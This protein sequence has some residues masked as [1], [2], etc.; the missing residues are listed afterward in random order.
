MKR[1][2]AGLVIGACLM[3]VPRAQASTIGVSMGA[4]YTCSVEN[5]G[6]DVS[7]TASPFVAVQQ[8]TLAAATVGNYSAM[9]LGSSVE[10]GGPIGTGPRQPGD[11]LALQISAAPT[12]TPEP[13]SLLLV[14]TGIAGLIIRRRKA[15]Q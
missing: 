14:G 3:I 1:I 2:V 4:K 15:R 9:G 7:R 6:T 11:T 8:A 13:A 5:C 10:P 12:A